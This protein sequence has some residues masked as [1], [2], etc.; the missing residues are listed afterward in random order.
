IG[1][2]SVYEHQAIVRGPNRASDFAK[3]DAEL[4]SEVLRVWRENHSIYG[5]RK[6]WHAM[7]REQIAIADCTV[8]RLM[9]ARV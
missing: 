8:E 4:R 5:A 7:K 3:R 6:L 9:A 1:S 2:S